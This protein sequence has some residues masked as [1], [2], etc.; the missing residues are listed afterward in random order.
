MRAINFSC[1]IKYSA[2]INNVLNNTIEKVD[3]KNV[4]QV[5]M[6]NAKNCQGAS[7]LINLHYPH[8]FSNGYATHS[9]NLVLKDWYTNESTTWFASIIDACCKVVKFILKRC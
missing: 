6:D 9:L 5:V 1:Q 2:Y 3:P 4:V 7:R 8:I